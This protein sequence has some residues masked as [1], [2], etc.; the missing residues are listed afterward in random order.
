MIE[1]PVF[2]QGLFAFEGAGLSHPIPLQP[3]VIYKVP[4][5]K[6]AQLV[7]FRAG[8]PAQELI[9]VLFRRD[10]KPM[11]YFPIPAKGATHV[12]LA[13]VEDLE[14]GT[15]LEVLLGAPQ[16]LSSSVLLD[17]SLVEIDA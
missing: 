12:E 9:Y 11:R 17:F 10:K 14:P 8:N 2:L 3:N 16:A 15:E 5:D 1:K 6:R 4:S 13:V 7:Y